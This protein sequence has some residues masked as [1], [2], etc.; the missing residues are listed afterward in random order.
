[1]TAFRA[2]LNTIIA[3]N[4]PGTGYL[5]QKPKVKSIFIRKD[6]PGQRR[7]RHEDL[8]YHSSIFGAAYIYCLRTAG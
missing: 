3:T 4:T 2:T 1:M 6:L 8:R 5:L 7:N